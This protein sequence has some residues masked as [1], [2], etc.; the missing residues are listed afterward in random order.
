[1]SMKHQELVMLGDSLSWDIIVIQTLLNFCLALCVCV[2]K[3][4][5][6]WVWSGVCHGIF[7]KAG[8]QHCVLVFAFHQEQA[9]FVVHCCMYQASWY[10]NF[11]GVFT[12]SS[13]HLAVET[14]IVDAYCHVQHHVDLEIQTQVLRIAQH[15]FF[16]WSH[17]PFPKLLIDL[18]KGCDWPN[19]GKLVL[20]I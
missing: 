14:E 8:G 7:V 18:S 11:Q 10:P 19:E 6:T 1:M 20:W 16:P 5:C 9:L 17:L 3:C 13:S 15:V 4:S 2:Y 12:S